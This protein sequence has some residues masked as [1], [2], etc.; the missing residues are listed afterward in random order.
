MCASAVAAEPPTELRLSY[1]VASD[2]RGMLLANPVP[3]G[4]W[5]S[6]TWQ[7]CAATGSCVTA[8]PSESSDRLLEVG[9]AAAGTTFVATASDGSQSVSATSVPYRGSVHTD[10]P[11][12]A[13]GQLR[14]GHFIKPMAGR[15]AGGWGSEGDVFQLQA[16]Q[17]R[18]DSSCKVIAD[19][20]VV[21]GCP[22]T[23]ARIRKRYLGWYVRVADTRVGHDAVFADRGYERAEDVKPL[24]ASGATAVATIGRVKPGRGPH[25]R[26]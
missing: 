7:A 14:V 5:G 6:V 26:C 18:R 4:S 1:L 12:R 17:T 9:D 22:G 24:A 13:S 16:C 21:D 23:G 25:G 10:S 19:P 20:A 11:P 2:G 8:H 15:W 3:D